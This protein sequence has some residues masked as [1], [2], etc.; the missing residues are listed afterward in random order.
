MA[1]PAPRKRAGTQLPNHQ[2]PAKRQAVEAF[3]ATAAPAATDAFSDLAEAAG[4]GGSQPYQPAQLQE[5]SSAQQHQPTAGAAD[6]TRTHEGACRIHT[7]CAA[8]G[9]L[10]GL[11]P[12]AAAAFILRESHRHS[13]PR[14]LQ[15]LKAQAEH[16]HQQ[17]ERQL[18]GRA[19]QQR[20]QQQQQQSERQQRQPALPVPAGKQQKVQH[21]SAA[22][23]AAAAGAAG[24]PAK[25]RRPA[26]ASTR[27]Q[28]AKAAAGT[29]AGAG[30]CTRV[31]A[32]HQQRQH[33]HPPRQPQ[34]Q[35]Q[36]HQ[37]PTQPL[38][39]QQQPKQQPPPQR[40]Q[41]QQLQLTRVPQPKRRP[42]PKALPAQ[43]R[44][45]NFLSVLDNI[46]PLLP[47]EGSPE[48]Q[49]QEA[50][51][52]QPA[53]EVF[54]PTAEDFAAAAA[55]ARSRDQ[56]TAAAAGVAGAQQRGSHPHQQ[57]QQGVGSVHEQDSGSYA[58]GH[59]DGSDAAA[60][61]DDG[62]DSVGAAAPTAEAYSPTAGLTAAAVTAGRAPFNPGSDRA[63]FY[64]PLDKLLQ[65]A[66]AAAAEAG[67]PG[68]DP[69]G[70][71]CQLG[72]S[73]MPAATAA[74]AA[75]GD[76]VPAVSG[77]MPALAPGA[78]QHQPRQRQRKQQRQ[79]QQQ[80]SPMMQLLRGGPA[81]HW[82]MP[83]VEDLRV[84]LDQEGVAGLKVLM[85]PSCFKDMQPEIKCAVAWLS[86]EQATVFHE[87]NGRT[88]PP[89]D[90]V[91]LVVVSEAIGVQGVLRY[92]DFLVAGVLVVGDAFLQLLHSRQ[93]ALTEQDWEVV[94][95]WLFCAAGVR[96][97]LDTTFIKL[98][99][100]AP[101]LSAAAAGSAGHNPARQQLASLLQELAA[102]KQLLPAGS[103]CGAYCLAGQQSEV[104]AGRLLQRWLTSGLLQP[105]QGVLTGL[106]G[107]RQ[108]MIQ[109][110]Q[111]QPASDPGRRTS[112]PSPGCGSTLRY[113]LLVLPD[114]GL[115]DSE[116]VLT[117]TERQAVLSGL[118]SDRLRSVAAGTAGQV[119]HFLRVLR[120]QLCEEGDGV[121]VG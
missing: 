96:L 7:C 117:D 120:Q 2:H 55:M 28:G 24:S 61:A 68:A 82:L 31:Q 109:Q 14:F 100:A 94:P 6:G 35:Q 75:G 108:V 121:G 101:A 29:G 77:Y 66:A 22:A 74:A 20:E 71:D 63:P 106:Q 47:I 99:A 40:Q 45:F 112:T 5:Q 10:A 8:G 42:A 17:A 84:L 76:Y 72:S 18:Q 81:E 30:D 33:R 118:A 73:Y 26:A 92:T 104:Q 4:T 23:A 70:G 44:Q 54:P 83:T 69:E 97:V 115:Q 59:E 88:V 46:N 51:G 13:L 48:E 90:K 49:E 91:N 56:A 39:K 41:K 27:T 60:A 78:N 119:L 32:G 98:A 15:L 86:A 12:L 19:Q 102:V 52:L 9:A 93:G 34:Q 65:Q 110:N 25:K 113:M 103:P 50:A 37:Q 89:P 11:S 57:K 114:L 3:A 21:L 36:T 58:T 67:G 87:P 111:L 38:Q 16:Q 53:P 80:V 107:A 1:S 64:S 85:E 95:R 43:A 62:A 105:L 116:G 79:Q